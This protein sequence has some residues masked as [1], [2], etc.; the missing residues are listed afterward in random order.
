MTKNPLLRFGAL[1]FLLVLVVR[2][3]RY[4]L[5][6]GPYYTVYDMSVIDTLQS[7]RRGVLKF[8]VYDFMGGSFVGTAVNIGI[9][10]PIPDTAVQE[11][12]EVAKLDEKFISIGEDGLRYYNGPSVED[13]PRHYVK[14]PVRSRL[15][16]RWPWQKYHFKFVHYP[17]DSIRLQIQVLDKGDCSHIDRFAATSFLRAGPCSY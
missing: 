11:Y 10:A 16:P 15:P 3:F 8:G 17:N 2:V 1:F 6:F 12:G 9:S 4:E 14:V 7:V 13:P 5:S